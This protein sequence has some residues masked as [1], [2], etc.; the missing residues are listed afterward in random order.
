MAI[1][2]DRS[3]MQEHAAAIVKGVRS[4]FDS[5]RTRDIAW[6]QRQLAGLVEMLE[7]HEEAFLDAMAADLG[8][9]RFEGWMAD[10][11]VTLRDANE[12]RRNLRSWARDERVRPPW[13]LLGTR[14]RIVRE[15]LGAVL[16]IAPWNYPIHLLV[17]PLAA[18]LAA[19]NTAVVKPSEVTP[20]VSGALA[21]YIPMHVDPEAVAVVEGGVPE[22]QALLTQR[23]DRIFYTG[24][25]HVG[26]QIAEAAARHLTPVTLE[27]G[28]K[29]PVIVDRDA[30]LDSAARRI[31]WGKFLNAG[32]T[33]VAPDYV[34]AHES[35][36]DALVDKLASTIRERYGDDPRTSDSF[37]RIVNERHALRLQGLLAAGGFKAVAC[38]GDVD[39]GARYV[40]PTVLAGV[41]PDA[42]VMGEEIF[43]PILPVL[44]VRDVDEAIAYVNGHDKPLALYVFTGSSRTADHVLRQTSS[45][46]ACV[47]EV[48]SH[49]LPAA[50]PF[51]GVGPSGTGAYHGRWG[52]EEFSHRKAVMD[53]PTWLEL[54]MMYAPYTALKERIVRRLF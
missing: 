2:E 50:L 19:G 48:V 3:T 11:R 47:N 40:A 6:R 14:N 36:H 42:A 35:V 26:R 15:P 34:L 49:V 54:A 1:T 29:S 31:V 18:A 21:R 46:G 23:F 10:L 53:R 51:G 8:R 37:G 33:C 17:S 38:G 9:P 16:V 5:G 27:L 24:N 22:T 7:E 44:P 43:G 32:Q 20:T 52:F 30:N 28:G 4:T 13:Q 25:G 12:L 45:G 41:D 39:A